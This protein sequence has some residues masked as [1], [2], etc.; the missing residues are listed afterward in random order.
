MDHQSASTET[1]GLESMGQGDYDFTNKIAVD[2]AISRHIAY[3][4]LAQTDHPE[5]SEHAELMSKAHACWKEDDD[6]SEC[7]KVIRQLG[8]E[9]LCGDFGGSLQR[10]ICKVEDEQIPPSVIN[11]RAFVN[12]KN[13]YAKKNVQWDMNPKVRVFYSNQAPIKSR[14]DE[15]INYT[16]DS[17]EICNKLKCSIRRNVVFYGSII[18]ILILLWNIYSSAGP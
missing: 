12:G 10:I 6:S 8:G 1:P 4:N 3:R 17:D 13:H 9:R 11:S 7:V 16:T 15:I 5:Y 14:D 18:I 2:T